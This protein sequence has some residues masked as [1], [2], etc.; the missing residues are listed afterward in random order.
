MVNAPDLGSGGL[1]PWRFETSRPYQLNGVV[2]NRIK[3]ITVQSCKECPKMSLKRAC[4]IRKRNGAVDEF[5]CT[6]KDGNFEIE[7][8]YPIQI[9]K[10]CPL[11][12][13]PM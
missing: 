1:C 10:R 3:I 6:H 11:A 7:V 8:E 2:M 9:D 4:V 5:W 13:Y 12:D